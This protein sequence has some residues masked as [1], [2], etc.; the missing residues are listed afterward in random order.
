MKPFEA[1]VLIIFG[2]KKETQYIYTYHIIQVFIVIS[3]HI[4]KSRSWNEKN[5]SFRRR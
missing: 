4:K 1:D 3:K 2:E 5:Y